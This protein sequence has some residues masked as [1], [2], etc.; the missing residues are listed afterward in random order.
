LFIVR[1]FNKL[2]NKTL[3]K[4]DLLQS[5]DEE[6]ET[7]TLLGVLERVNLKHSIVQ[8]LRLAF[9]GTPDRGSPFPHLKTETGPVSVSFCFK[10]VRIPDVG[11]S[12][13]TQ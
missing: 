1:N 2:E 8:S 4:L 6:K 12:P 7:P 13:E 5:S 9:S 11:Q 3:Q 10:F